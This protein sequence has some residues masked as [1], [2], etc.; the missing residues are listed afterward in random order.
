MGEN[1]RGMSVLQ[2]ADWRKFIYGMSEGLT[3][4]WFTSLVFFIISFPLRVYLLL[5]V[6]YLRAGQNLEA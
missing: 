4:V 3:I 6:F 1:G 5:N 2:F